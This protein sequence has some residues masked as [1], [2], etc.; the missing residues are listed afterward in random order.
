[1]GPSLASSEAFVH[2]A[3]ADDPAGRHDRGSQLPYRR[4]CS[5]M[6]NGLG[7]VLGH[8]AP[9]V[10]TTSIRRG[11]LAIAKRVSPHIAA[12]KGQVGDGRSRFH[13]VNLTRRNTLGVAHERRDTKSGSDQN[14]FVRDV[15]STSTV[16]T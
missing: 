15:G 10:F 3:G 1:C 11:P 4:Q 7:S 6:L 5:R 8:A 13:R 9:I 12:Q 2:F 16:R 14:T